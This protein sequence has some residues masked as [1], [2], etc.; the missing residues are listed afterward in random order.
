MNLYQSGPVRWIFLGLLLLALI[1]L[2]VLQRRGWKIDWRQSGNSL[3]IAI[4]QRGVNLISASLF[5]GLFFWVWEHRLWT[6]AMPSWWG[7]SLLFL[8]QEFCYYWEHRLSHECRWFWASHVVHHS[9]AQLNLSAAYRLSWTAGFTGQLLFFLP[10]VALG[11]H[12]LAVVAMVGVNLLYQF[13]LHTEWIPAL[14]WFDTV[15]N[16]PSNHRV[17]HASNL[18]YLDANYGGVL[19]IFDRMFGTWIKESPAEPCIFGLV[20]PLQSK[21]PLVILFHE[22]IALGHDMGAAASWREALD[23]LLKPPGWRPGGKGTTTREMRK[24]RS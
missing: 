16:S 3:L 21:N 7:I 10:L 22:W 23:Y 11:F 6:V 12:P 2:L 8:L 20:K 15:F 9:P 24:A 5:G 1:E 13:W 18:R 17:H 4:G 19:I 14:G